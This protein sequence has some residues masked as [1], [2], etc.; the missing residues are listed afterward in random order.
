MNDFIKVFILLTIIF[1]IKSF[2]QSYNV[3][4]YCNLVTETVGSF[5]DNPYHHSNT[6]KVHKL[7]EEQ[8]ETGDELFKIAWD[9]NRSDCQYIKNSID[10]I[11]LIDQL[12]GE[13][14]GSRT[15]RWDSSEMRIIDP[16][17]SAFGW[18][19]TMLC[20]CE[21]LE[22]FQY[23]KDEFKMVLAH[24]T[25]PKPYKDYVLDL[26]WVNYKLYHIDPYTKKM[27][28]FYQ[29]LIEGDRYQLVQYKDDNNA[30]RSSYRA[31]KKATS[32]RSSEME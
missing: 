28:Y 23:K 32:R 1:P 8:L 15:V 17:L 14:S 18:Q 22:V 25:R 6:E 26:N 16:I 2:S 9:Y 31:I 3:R 21:D 30:R 20:T 12:V 7:L 29:S 4:L 19:K 13:I 10:I 5:F 27:S 11:K 24:N